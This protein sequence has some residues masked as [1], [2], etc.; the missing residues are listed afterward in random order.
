MPRMI[1]VS[2]QSGRRAGPGQWVAAGGVNVDL[3][4]F[5]DRCRRGEAVLQVALL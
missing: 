2:Y 1:K 4:L 3:A 5:I